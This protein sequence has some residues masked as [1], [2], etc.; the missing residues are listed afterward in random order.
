MKIYFVRTTDGK[1]VRQKFV[2]YMFNVR[3]DFDLLRYEPPERNYLKICAVYIQCTEG[4]RCGLYV[5]V[6]DV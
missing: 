3:E 1:I 4:L 5:K 6:Y 2:Q